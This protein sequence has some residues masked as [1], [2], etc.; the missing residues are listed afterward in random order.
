[1]QAGLA[2][3]ATKAAAGLAAA[4]IVTAG[5]VEARHAAK[6]VQQAKAKPVQVAA[7]KPLAERQPSTS[8][9][10]LPA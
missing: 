9:F 6:P 4:A 7:A 8:A 2:T 1:M 3:V 5:A 10:R